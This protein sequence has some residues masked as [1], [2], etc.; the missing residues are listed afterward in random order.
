MCCNGSKGRDPNN[1]VAEI[2]SVQK[3]GE[4]MKTG[5]ALILC[6]FVLFIFSST[7]LTVV[8]AAGPAETSSSLNE[9]PQSS[10]EGGEK[11]VIYI[12]R[13][14]RIIGAPQDYTFHV[15]GVEMG[16]VGNKKY[17]RL[18]LDPGVHSIAGDDLDES[19]KKDFEAGRDYYINIHFGPVGGNIVTY[20]EPEIGKFEFESI[21]KKKRKKIKKIEVEE[22]LVYE[23]E[24]TVEPIAW[25][26]DP[27]NIAVRLPFTSGKNPID[28][29][30]GPVKYSS[31][32]VSIDEAGGSS[33]IVTLSIQA[34]NIGDT[35]YM[36]IICVKLQDAN[37]ADVVRTFFYD[38]VEEEK[39]PKDVKCVMELQGSDAEAVSSILVKLW[40]KYETTNSKPKD[41]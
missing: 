32:D 22:I 8:L 41:Y 2:N 11:T 7:T 34:V 31:I 37:G 17:V 5:L 9:H 26:E 35:D 25:V 20:M 21:D 16:E 28:K 4:V 39:K 23:D 24:A 12:Y 40:S 30:I 6:V 3:E 36:P 1:P 15:D 29:T 18:E 38:E 27:E 14:P 33:K 19:I 13:F 10:G